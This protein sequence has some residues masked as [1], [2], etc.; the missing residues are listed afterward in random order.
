MPFIN[1]KVAGQPLAQSQV[2]RLQA[3]VTSLM[4]EILHKV[5]PLVGV[6]VEQRCRDGAWAANR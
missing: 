5:G 2:Q 3:D 1:V 6:L 4:A